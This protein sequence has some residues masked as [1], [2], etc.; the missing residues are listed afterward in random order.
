MLG[1]P[2]SA[3]VPAMA[4]SFLLV[5]SPSVGPRTW[6]PVAHRLAELGRE[7]VVPSLLHVGDE[8]PPFWPRVV[9]AVRAGLGTVGQDQGV[10]LVAH[11]NAGLFIPVIAAA[12]PGQVRGCIF[13]DAALPPASGTAPMVPPELLALLRD[14]ASG[15]RLPRWTDWWDEEQVAPLFPDQAT[16]AAVTEEQPRLPLSYYEASVPVPAGWDARPCAYLLFGPPY[17][18]LAGQARARG[19]IVERLPGRH[20]HQLVDPDGVAR[21]LVALAERM[22]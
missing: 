5:H 18:E 11:S 2:T 15:G 10:V 8:G 21:R 17:D 7:A 20:L 4:T 19:W 13:V 6:H 16:R 14:K 9:D 22:G 3:T 1:Q 12:L